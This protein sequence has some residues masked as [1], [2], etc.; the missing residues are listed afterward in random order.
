MAASGGAEASAG[1][2]ARITS[3][4]TSRC[5]N[6]CLCPSVRIVLHPPCERRKQPLIRLAAVVCEDAH[7]RLR[8]AAQHRPIQRVLPAQHW[9]AAAGPESC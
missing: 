4:S 5:A 9:E 7:Q 8:R 1:A 6:T 3:K 2:S